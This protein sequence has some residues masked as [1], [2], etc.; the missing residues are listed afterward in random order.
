MGMGWPM[1]SCQNSGAFS[2]R[3]SLSTLLT[4]RIAGLGER[5]RRW[6]AARSAGVRPSAT[7]VSRMMASASCIAIWA[8]SWT[9]DWMEPAGSG[10]RPPVSSRMK[11][12]PSQSVWAIRRSRVVPAMSETMAWRQPTMRLNRDDLPTLGRPTMAMMGKG[13]GR[14]RLGFWAGF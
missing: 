4:A 12:R 3:L 1:P 6:A 5:R 10:S 14:P 2:S 13:I 11:G 9:P 8:C 7:S